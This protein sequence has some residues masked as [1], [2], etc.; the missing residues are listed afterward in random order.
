[1]DRT[2]TMRRSWGLALLVIGAALLLQYALGDA[3]LMNIAVGTLV[4]IIGQL[5]P[6]PPK[7]EARMVALPLVVRLIVAVGIILSFSLLLIAL[8]ELTSPL[9]IPLSVLLGGAALLIASRR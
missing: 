3:P 1:M 7:F 4:L 9:A 5:V 2:H 6:L 8:S